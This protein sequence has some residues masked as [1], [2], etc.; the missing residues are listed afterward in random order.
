[1]PALQF[2][3]TRLNETLKE[4]NR[5]TSGRGTEKLRAVLVTVQ[6]ALA[7]IL[8]TVGGLLI[9]SMRQLQQVNPG[10][11]PEQLLTMQ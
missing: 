3:R 10:F 8:L 2:S 4:G 9:R 11:N 5:G 7:L 6:I 1:M